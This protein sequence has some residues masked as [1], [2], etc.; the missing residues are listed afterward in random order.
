M[1]FTK[2]RGPGIHNLSD[3]TIRNINSSGIITSTRFIGQVDITSGSIVATAATFTGN[4]SVGGTL[5][6]EDVKSV[7]SIGIITARSDVHVGAGISVV[8]VSTFSNTTNITGE[9]RANGNVKI[10]NVGPKIT[11][12]DTNNDDDFEIKNNNGVFT[13]RDATNSV[14]RLAIDSSGN[15][16]V[17]V[18]PIAPGHTTLHIGNSA[19]SQ[20]VRLHMTTNGTG[21]TASD[22]FSLSIDGSSSAVNLIQ[23]ESA[24]MQFYTAGTERLRIGPTGISTFTNDVRI[25]KSAGPLLE[26]TTNTGAADATLRLSEGATG[27]TNNGGGMFYSGADNKLHI[28]CGTNS[29]TKRIT[30]DRD[31]GKVGV[32]TAAPAKTLH[33]FKSN[34]H[35]LL[36]ERGDSANTQVELRTGGVVRG[37]WGCSTTSNFMVYDNDTSDINFTVLQTG[38][39]GIGIADPSRRLHVKSAGANATQIALID[40]DSTNEVFQ[41]GQQ[42]DGDCFVSIRDDSGSTKISFDASGTSILNGGL[43]QIGS[44]IDNS[45]D[46]DST[47]TKLTIKQTANS[48]EDGIYIER[49]GERRGW[50][51]Y[52]G[53]G[54]SSDDALCFDTNQLGTDTSVLALDRSG[55]VKIAGYLGVNQT[56]PSTRLDVRQD[57]GV[58]YN[59]NA[60]SIANN[61]ARFLN[62][63][64]HTSGGTYTGFQFNISGDSQN[65]ICS[66]GMITEASNGK[67]S[68]LVFHTDDN[69][70]RTE[71]LRIS[72]TGVLTSKRSSTNA[73]SSNWNGAAISI[74][75]THDTDNNASV[76]WFEN[77]AGGVDCAIQGI[78]QD[79]AGTGGTRRGHIQFGTSG[80][81]SSGSIVERLRIESEGHLLPGSDNSLNLGSSAKRW[82]NIYTGDLQL[83]NV[84]GST[85]QNGESITPVGNEVDNTQGTWTIQEGSNDLFIINRLNGKKYKFNLTEVS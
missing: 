36:L 7:D 34:E 4:V 58:A 28:T 38:N 26:L 5:T 20:P 52:V 33:I 44:A 51:Q 62:T 11:L 75:N 60:Q 12:V 3:I 73:T 8:G 27:T 63:S 18:A 9:L 65:R 76:I 67:A 13:I 46:I 39:T 83:S 41:I 23:R 47:N 37:Y 6:Y 45:G 64:G 84:S 54:L 72:S 43:V 79:A 25:V 50:Y 16:G 74:K 81:N 35:P 70:N 61:A 1:A 59:G 56:S 40:N 85:D 48:R 32:G 30:I 10:S 77:S 14:D 24:D 82:A 17:G 57:N 29:T 22:G 15:M 53:G 55:N 21:A 80:S 66:I 19:S 2:V 42:S 68:S 78:H 71:K 31:T 49:S 69:G